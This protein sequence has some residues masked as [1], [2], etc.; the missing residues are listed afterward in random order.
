MGR[1]DLKNRTPIGSALDTD[2]YKQ[3]KEY[4]AETKIPISKILDMA[5]EQFLESTKKK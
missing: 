4:S 2:I 5:I 1:K 3:L